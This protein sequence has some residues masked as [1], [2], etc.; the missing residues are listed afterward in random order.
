MDYNAAVLAH[1]RWKTRLKNHLMGQ[2]QVDPGSVAK[3]DQ[4]DLG[5][6]IYGDG[7]KHAT[8]SAFADLKTKH[9]KFHLVAANVVNSARSRPRDKA[10]ELIDPLESEFGRATSDVI[11]ALAAAKTLFD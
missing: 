4:C 3:D 1:S 6:W 5:K 9:T 2:E 8:L 11:N 7:K 10:L